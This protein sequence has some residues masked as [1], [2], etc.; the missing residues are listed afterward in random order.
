MSEWLVYHNG[1]LVPDTDAK[2]HYSDSGLMFGVIVTESTRTF[3]H[4][5]FKLREH[6]D[7]LFRSMK[8][9]RIDPRMGTGEME[10]ITL[11]VWDA[12]RHNLGPND[13]AWIVHNVTGGKMLVTIGGWEFGAPTVLINCAP[14]DFT[15]FGAF[16]NTGV[17]AI[18]PS[19]RQIPPQCLDPKIKHRNRLHFNL[20]EYQVKAV[21]PYG[22]SLLLDINGNLAENKGANFFV[23]TGGALRTPTPH[24]VLAG[25]SRQ[26]VLELAEGLGIPTVE[27]DL[28][29]YDVETADEAFFTSTPYC[30]LPA[31]RINGVTIGDGLPGPVSR[32]LLAAWSEMV[33][34]DIVNQAELHLQTEAMS[35]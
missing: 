13:D 2:V 25:V 29:L 19:V 9:T 11:E 33:G 6:I 27:E 22:F 10:K 5:P 1:K 17:H 14:I 4:T 35:G 32:R 30:L 3:A 34:T 12:N 21:D 31:T 8:A 28:Q 24:S 26:T 18:T 16:Y 7:R 20:A 23:V 15:A